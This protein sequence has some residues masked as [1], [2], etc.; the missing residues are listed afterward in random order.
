MSQI[1][2]LKRGLLA[3][4]T[5]VNPILDAGEAVYVIDQNKLKVGDG[6]SAFTALPYLAVDSISWGDIDG[7]L[8]NQADLVAALGAKQDTLVS[9]VNIKTVNGESLLGSSDIEVVASV[10]SANADISVD[11]TDPTAPILTL[12]AALSGADKIVRLNAQGKL[13]ESVLPALAIVDTY[14]VATEVEQLALTVQKGDVAIRTDI[15]KT[16]INKTGANASMADWQEMIAP[17]TGVT[18]VQAG[19]GMDFSTITSSGSVIMG[20]P[21]SIT[22]SST[23]SASGTTHTHALSIDSDDVPEG[24]SNLYFTE[25]RARASVSAGDGVSYNNTTGVVSLNV[26]GTT[27]SF[28]GG[29]LNIIKIDGGTIV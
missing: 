5:S 28:A 16:F 29:V 21:S 3:A 22:G 11:S 1:I 13:D 24:A 14:V 19:A 27:F 25:A 4:L 26:N 9:G 8:A 7:S 23:N 12:N 10:S 17:G 6:V 20:T 2:A 18:A 15:G